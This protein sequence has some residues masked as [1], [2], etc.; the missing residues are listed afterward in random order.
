MMNENDTTGK[1]IAIV[2]KLLIIIVILA[3]G[4]VAITFEFYNQKD[5]SASKE[6]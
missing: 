3:I 4:I 5:L 2:N 6:N 1:L